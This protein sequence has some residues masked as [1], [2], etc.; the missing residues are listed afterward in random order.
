M[1][2]CFEL[3]CRS[4]TDCFELILDSFDKLKEQLSIQLSDT[5]LKIAAISKNCYRTFSYSEC[6]DETLQLS[7]WP[8]DDVATRAKI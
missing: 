6:F 1:T 4:Y 7:D 3:T 8:R 2:K 5:Y